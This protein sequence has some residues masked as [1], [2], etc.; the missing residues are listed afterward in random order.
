[1]SYADVDEDKR[2]AMGYFARIDAERYSRECR[3]LYSG[4]QITEAEEFK[5]VVADVFYRRRVFL[6]Y[7]EKFVTVKVEAPKKVDKIGSVY[8]NLMSLA[9]KRGY[10][11]KQGKASIIFEIK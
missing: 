7:R 1:M 10:T 5:D 4:V 11:V 9:D 2:S 6:N 3:N 8:Q